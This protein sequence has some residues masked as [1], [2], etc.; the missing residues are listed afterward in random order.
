MPS[1]AI[2]NEVV[3]E[4]IIGTNSVT[5]PAGEVW[6]AQVHSHELNGTGRNGFTVNGTQ[7]TVVY[8]NT[9]KIPNYTTFGTVFVGGDTLS[10]TSSGMR[11]MVSGYRVDAGDRPIDD[12]AVSVQ[13]GGADSVTVPT[14]EVWNVTVVVSTQNS[15]NRSGVILNG[16]RIAEIYD[17]N[18]M[19]Q[20][21]V[22]D[23]LLQEGDTLETERSGMGAQIGGFKL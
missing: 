7:V 17:N 3:S 9:T 8:N 21:Q 10:A 22:F 20:A 4:H 12:A 6:Q 5:V 16:T 13:L 15:N 19:A 14:G 11:N 23:L 2:S 1:A 18:N